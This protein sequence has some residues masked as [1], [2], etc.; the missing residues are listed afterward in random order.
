MRKVYRVTLAADERAELEALIRKGTGAAQ[1]LAR[2]RI[3]LKA[4]QGTDGP[5]WAD[6][7]VADALDVAVRTVGNV[8]QRF[9]EGGLAGALDR[10]PQCRPSKVRLLD[11][12]AEARLVALACSEPPAGRAHWTL[13][14]LADRLVEL[15][16]VETISADTVG[17][18]M[19]KTRSNRG[20]WTSG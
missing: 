10:K 11:G 14:L 2:A 4:D 7:R 13:Q 9:V 6:E 5:A 16:V 18:A 19:K 12:R 15:R 20:G 17:R 1:R 8:R 3:L